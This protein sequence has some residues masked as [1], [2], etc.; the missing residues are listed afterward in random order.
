M[1]G[2]DGIR[3]DDV[4]KDDEAVS[5][6]LDG[7][8]DKDGAAA[9]EEMAAMNEGVALR[10]ARLRHMDDL[11]RSAIPEEDSVPRALLDR[12]GIGQPIKSGAKVVDLAQ[13]RASRDARRS[14]VTPR[15]R[16]AALSG[17]WR[18][19][20]QVTLVVGLGLAG[21][22]YLGR[23][24]DAGMRA[25]SGPR[26]VYTALGDAT[27]TKS[28]ANAVVMFAADVDAAEGRAIFSRVGASV[29]SGPSAGGAWQLAIDPA[30][31]S[32]VLAGLRQR[33]DV[34]MAEPLDGEQP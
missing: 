12:L 21:I 19:A 18:V 29:V 7:G 4:I 27:A 8:L 17:G 20:A 23:G 13:A 2:K 6:W 11:V 15:P 25:V 3:H 10:A 16:I 24:D 1:S 30:K 5:A 31:R 34:T 22:V 32:D 26:A 33:G 9:M 28:T 14:P